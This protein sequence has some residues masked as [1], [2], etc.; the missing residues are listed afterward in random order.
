MLF[1]RGIVKDPT[2]ATFAMLDPVTIPIME[3]AMTAI[4]A[5]PPRTIP[6]S[7]IATFIMNLPT[8]V[9]RMIA[10]KTMKRR[11]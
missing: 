3:L 8:A 1:I 6:T 11:M 4:F 7:D 2:P 5:G 10:A 9:L